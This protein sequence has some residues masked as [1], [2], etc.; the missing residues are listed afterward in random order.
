M[1]MKI[2][3]SL[4]GILLLLTGCRS[5]SQPRAVVGDGLIQNRA[6]GAGGFSF[7]IPAEFEVYRP[8]AKNQA[9]YNELQKMAIR[10]YE[11]DKPYHPR[12]DELFYESFLLVSEKT[13]FLLI[14][15][16]ANDVARIDDNP[17]AD[18]VNSKWELMP[19]YNV[20]VRRTFELSD[21]RLSAVYTRGTAHERKG[22]Y[23]EKAK[24]G[25]TPFSYEACKFEGR[26]RDHYILMGFAAADQ[27][28]ALTAP[29][30]RMAEGI[31]FAAP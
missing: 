21:S 20:S 12:G 25:S 11:T 13:C 8:A 27:A 22:W 23:Y 19:L 14:T 3:V 9:E 10:I 24:R 30:R 18:A 17:F 5:I 7:K 16:K 1:K 26:N 28:G 29:M 15:F 4:M 2:V 31:S 6:L